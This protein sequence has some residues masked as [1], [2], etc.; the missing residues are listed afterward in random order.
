MFQLTPI[1]TNPADGNLVFG[2][3]IQYVQ[4]LEDRLINVS[5]A[6]AGRPDTISTWY[7]SDPALWW[8]INDLSQLVD[9]LLDFQPGVQVRFSPTGLNR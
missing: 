3:R 6:T 4:Q 8:L 9:P 2:L 5:M 1:Y 7:Q